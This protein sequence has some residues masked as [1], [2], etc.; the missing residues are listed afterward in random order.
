M[1]VELDKFF[2]KSLDSIRIASV[3]QKLEKIFFLQNSAW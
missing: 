1:I 2:F 3:N